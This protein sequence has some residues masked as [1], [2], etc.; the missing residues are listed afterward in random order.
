M[1]FAEVGRRRPRVDGR[2]QVTGEVRYTAD[3]HFPG[4]LYAKGLL[5]TEDHARILEL[6]TSAAERLPGVR[7]VA[8]ARD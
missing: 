4:M 3:L 8:T 2:Q 5:S 7:A 1:K 6:D